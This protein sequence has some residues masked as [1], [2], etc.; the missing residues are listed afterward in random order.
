M[1]PSPPPGWRPSP[2]TSSCNFTDAAGRPTSGKLGVYD[3]ESFRVADARGMVYALKAKGGR[4]H[5]RAVAPGE[6]EGGETGITVDQLIEKR[7][8][9]IS[10]LEEK[11]DGE[12][13]PKVE[14]CEN[15]ARHLRNLVVPRLGRKIAREVT[16][17]DI[18]TLSDDIAA[19]KYVVDGKARKRSPS[20]A[21][22]FRRACSSMFKWAMEPGDHHF[23]DAN[24]CVNLPKLKRERPK[25][26]VLSEDE[27]RTLWHGLD[28]NDLPWD[29]TTRLAIRFALCSM[30][31]SNE[32]LPIHR[33]EIEGGIV[34]IPAKRVKKRRLIRQP[35]SDLALSIL[36]ESM[37]DNEFAFAGR[38]GDAPLSRQAMS[39][40]L[41][42]TKQTKGIC[43]LLGMKKFTTHD[44]RDR[45]RRRANTFGCRA[46]ISRLL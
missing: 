19:G 14:S 24:P 3:P 17:D 40:A 45:R 4:R 22:H 35:L 10:T 18:A 15:V 46:A 33:S 42:G 39:G 26:R 31:R 44:L 5:R 20:N 38:F 12:M 28:R 25:T 2:V 36:K 27:I 23:V 43:E 7:I 32:L 9:A 21:R 11:D 13:R 34:N 30:L 41:C 8:E 37:G 29:R 1:S 6:G 16:S